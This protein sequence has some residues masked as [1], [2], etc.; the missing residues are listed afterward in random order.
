MHCA[1]LFN[2][3]VCYDINLKLMLF[4]N[5]IHFKVY[6]INSTNYF[7]TFFLVFSLFSLFLQH[8]TMLISFIVLI[9]LCI[10]YIVYLLLTFLFSL[11]FYRT[12]CIFSLISNRFHNYSYEFFWF[13]ILIIFKLLCVWKKRS[14][15]LFNESFILILVQNSALL[16][17]NLS[18][19]F[20]DLKK[21]Q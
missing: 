9:F 11:I 7:S 16:I 2:I 21:L 18:Q 4:S 13:H 12:C 14:K 1:I 15:R 8:F 10:M 19:S 17:Q 20:L 3:S 6:L 5:N